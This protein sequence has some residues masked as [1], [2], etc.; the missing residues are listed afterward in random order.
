MHS[1]S[2]SLAHRPPPAARTK[3][4]WQP[5]NSISSGPRSAPNFSFISTPSSSVSPPPQSSSKLCDLKR[6]RR[7]SIPSMH[8]TPPIESP[9]C[10]SSGTQYVVS[11]VGQSHH[12][13]ST[14]ILHHR[15]ITYQDWFTVGHVKHLSEL[16]QPQDIPVIFLTSSQVNVTMLPPKNHPPHRSPHQ[17]QDTQLPSPESPN[18][19][20][21]AFLPSSFT[22]RPSFPDSPS[23]QTHRQGSRRPRKSGPT[24]GLCS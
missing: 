21:A 7:P 18:M 19:Q 10:D 14:C 6:I 24:E 5:Y 13:Y 12:F 11:L 23:S 1:V 9:L 8:P 22:R 15:H 4:R 17:F 3:V 2:H 20:Q 16:F